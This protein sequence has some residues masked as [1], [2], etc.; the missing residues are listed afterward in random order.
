MVHEPDEEFAPL[1]EAGAGLADRAGGASE[2]PE[3]LRRRLEVL[4]RIPLA[5]PSLGDETER[6]VRS[7]VAAS[8]G[9]AS[10][11]P[12]LEGSRKVIAS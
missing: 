7:S 2:T 4:E 6:R 1:Q 8:R 12:G 10:S 5:Y 3:G 11:K 9:G